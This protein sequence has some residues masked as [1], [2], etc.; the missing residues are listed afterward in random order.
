MKAN[1]GLTFPVDT[2]EGHLVGDQRHHHLPVGSNLRSLH[3]HQISVVD[4]ISD[5]RVSTH[6][7]NVVFPT[8][9]K[10]CR[11]EDALV[12]RY[13]LY[14]CAGCD[15][16]EQG[17]IGRLRLGGSGPWQNQASLLMFLPFEIA[18][19][20]EMG[21]MLLRTGC[22]SKTERVRNFLQG[23]GD[24]IIRDSLLDELQDVALSLSEVGHPI[25]SYLDNR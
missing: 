5:H 10:I 9:E 3:D 19:T 23:R 6:A 18:L 7:K 21:H 24:A 2:F 12:V 16:S 4:P 15:N 14:G 13:G 25:A 22:A 11:H 20:F 8:A 17:Q 1:G